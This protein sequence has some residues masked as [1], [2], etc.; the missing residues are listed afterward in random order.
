MKNLDIYNSAV[1]RFSQNEGVYSS[2]MFD[3]ATDIKMVD[4]VVEV[5]LSLSADQ[6]GCGGDVRTLDPALDSFDK[7]KLIPML[8]FVDPEEFK[9]ENEQ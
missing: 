9:E 8:V 2:A 5:K 4:N 3:H 1:K 6:L 7:L